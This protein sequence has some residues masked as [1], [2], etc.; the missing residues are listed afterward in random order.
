MFLEGLKGNM[1]KK[2]FKALVG[3]I[4]GCLWILSLKSFVNRMIHILC[5]KISPKMWKL[6][7][8][9]VQLGNVHYVFVHFEK[10]FCDESVV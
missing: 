9:H 5:A 2:G 7:C 3:D 1:G 8:Q 10:S 4:G 6:I